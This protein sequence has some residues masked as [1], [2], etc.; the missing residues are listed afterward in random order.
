MLAEPVNLAW[1]PETWD[2]WDPSGIAKQ[3]D[4]VPA[5]WFVVGGWALDLFHGRTTRAHD[6]LEIAVPMWDFD[7]IRAR[8]S[9]YEFFVAGADGF[10]PVESGAPPT[11][12]INRPWCATRRLVCGAWT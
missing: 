5:R 4:G 3:L 1:G 6:D 7:L 9:A 10:W 8:L 12:S 2:S 11:S